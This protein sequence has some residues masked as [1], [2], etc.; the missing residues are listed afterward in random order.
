MLFFIYLFHVSTVIKITW[1]KKKRN[2]KKVNY[3]K[4]KK[5]YIHVNENIDTINYNMKSHTLRP[6]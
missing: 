5:I 4:N 2:L 1:L 6:T 3:K